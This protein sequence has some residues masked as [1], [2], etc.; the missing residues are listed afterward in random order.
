MADIF[1]PAGVPD[2]PLFPLQQWEM[3]DNGYEASV[4]PGQ[5]RTAPRSLGNAINFTADYPMSRHQYFAIF[6]PWWSRRMSLGG[7]DNGVTPF[8]LRDPYERIPYRVIRQIGQK[9][10]PQRDGFGF[11]VRLPLHRF[12]T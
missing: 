6:M 9:M 2:S 4:A 11:V 8:W 3:V 7:C 12:A 5:L 1:W 10:D